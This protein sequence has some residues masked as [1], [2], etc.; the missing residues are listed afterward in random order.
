VRVRRRHRMHYRNVAEQDRSKRIRQRWSVNTRRKSTPRHIPV[1]TRPRTRTSVRPKGRASVLSRPSVAQHLSTADAEHAPTLYVLNAAAITKPSAIEHLTA[2]LVSYNIDMA[3]ITETHLKKKHADHRF[4][5]DD[6]TLIHRDRVRRR[7]GGVAVYINKRLSAD[8]WTW[9]GD[10]P[11][12]ELL[13]V[14]V[15]AEGK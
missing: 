13:W 2:D 11:E 12:I 10:S 5:V 14:R 8:V 9:P 1:V 3:V 6:Y 7:G 15:H 4:A